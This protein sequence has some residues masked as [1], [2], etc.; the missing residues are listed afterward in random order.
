M[1]YLDRVEL[2]EM[3]VA[4]RIDRLRSKIDHAQAL[5][6]RLRARKLLTTADFE[7]LTVW[8]RTLDEI[9]ESGLLRPGYAARRAG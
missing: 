2:A 7:H 1:L 3:P 9:A 4:D 5:G 6:R 8:S